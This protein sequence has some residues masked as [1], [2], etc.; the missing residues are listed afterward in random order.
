MQSEGAV[1]MDRAVARAAARRGTSPARGL[2]KN[3]KLCIHTV[4]DF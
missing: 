4:S 3:L 2:R 1:G